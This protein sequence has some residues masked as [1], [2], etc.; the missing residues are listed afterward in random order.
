MYA[1]ISW[2]SDEPDA[3]MS[4]TS[5]VVPAWA[6]LPIISVAVRASPIATVI[7]WWIDLIGLAPWPP[8]ETSASGVSLLLVEPPA[9]HNTVG[10]FDLW[11]AQPIGPMASTPR[12]LGRGCR[13]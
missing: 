12:V 8:R 6:M 3:L 10:Q 1:T 2:I 4:L 7:V 11:G 9:Q 5:L 13:R